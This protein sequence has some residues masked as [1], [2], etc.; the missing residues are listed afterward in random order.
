[1]RT[2]LRAAA[3]LTAL[4]ICGAA[5]AAVIGPAAA[6]NV[7]IFGS[8][9][10]MSQD[11]D[12][13]GDLAA[14]GNVTL[15]NYSVAQGIA[16]D[17]T[18]S[19]NP[20]RIVVGGKLTAT[21]GGVG[22]GSSNQ[23]GAIYYGSS[24]PSLTSFTARGGEFAN[25]SLVN[26]ATSASLY[27]SYSSQLGALSANG[28]TSF[29]SN[30]DTLTFTGT[31]S[32]LNVFTVSGAT[33]TSSNTID[34]SAPTGSTVLIN[35]TGS[36]ASFQNGSV[37]ETGVTDASVLYNFITATSV[38][39]VGS[40]DPMGSI[41]APDAGVTG[42]FGAMDGQLIAGSYSGNTQF[43]EV[44]FAGNL[45]STVPLPASVTLLGSGLLGLLLWRARS[46]ILS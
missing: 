41:L 34:I 10:F 32:G 29:N 2:P 43:N 42:G 6:Y 20:A 17:P 15:M 1:M 18:Q 30:G 3:G 37:M 27:S 24:T 23:D 22:S 11:T 14:G 9:S 28:T 26:F 33:L 46:R 4:L 13:M 16:G 21:N 36:S 35:V 38:D 8:G 5:S 39:L 7:F 25:Q 12:T 40:K 45:P 31:A 44:A 19:P